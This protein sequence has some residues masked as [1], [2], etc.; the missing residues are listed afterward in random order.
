MVQ[1][2]FV[3]TKTTPLS[4]SE[5][6][7][8]ILAGSTVI[9]IAFVLKYSGKGVLKM[10]PFTKLIDEDKHVE[11][12]LVNKVTDLSSKKVEINTSG[13]VGKKK[14]DDYNEFDGDQD[15]HYQRDNNV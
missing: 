9:P 6:G 14:N 15:D 1:Y 10:I 7:A 13:F 2:L 4:R 5:W 3:F 8:C 11:D 12:G